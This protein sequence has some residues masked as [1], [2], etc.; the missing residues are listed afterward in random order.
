MSDPVAALASVPAGLRQPLLEKYREIS[1]NF[2]ERRWTPAELEGGKLAE[3]IF[4]IVEG[5]LSG[6]YALAPH[7]PENF[8]RAC[9]A[10]ENLPADAARPDDHSI[11]ILVPRM[12]VAL[13]DIRNNRSVGHIGGD[14]DPNEAD[15]TVVHSISSWLV[16]ELVRIYHGLPI[17]AAQ[18]VVEALVERKVPLVWEIGGKKRVLNPAIDKNKQT[19]LLLYSEPGWVM[20]RDLQFWVEYGEA[21]K[22]RR[23]ILEPLHKERLLEYEPAAARVQI[24]PRGAIEV[25]SQLLPS[26][27]LMWN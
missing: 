21:C 3:I 1:T 22:F 14:V 24:S 15:A 12:L 20:E 5:R 13:Y 10:I 8:A 2:L 4:T 9:R 17:D 19:L 25:E 16:S 6:A 18:K 23:R 27:R 7:K 11:R 26:L